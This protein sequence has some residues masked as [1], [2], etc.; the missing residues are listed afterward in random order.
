M[1][2]VGVVMQEAGMAEV[3]PLA[4]A[5]RTR[6]KDGKEKAGRAPCWTNFSI[7]HQKERA[8]SYYQQKA[9]AGKVRKVTPKVVGQAH[10]KANHGIACQK[11]KVGKPLAKVS[12][13]REARM[14]KMAKAGMLAMQAKAG[15]L[16][17]REDGQEK[18]GMPKAKIQA[19]V[20]IAR[21][22]TVKAGMGRKAK[23][24]AIGT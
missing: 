14:A 21:A 5:G 8:G 4:K 1:V 18:V 22:G 10:P 6:A 19:W 9:R 3:K 24:R 17:A 7:L 20:K 23:K 2:K 12:A 15:S 11:A 16:L 13:G